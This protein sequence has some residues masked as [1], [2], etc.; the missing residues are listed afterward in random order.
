MRAPQ[1]KTPTGTSTANAHIRQAGWCHYAQLPT[2]AAAQPIGLVAR[3]ANDGCS[4]RSAALP[5]AAST[6]KGKQTLQ[7]LPNGRDTRATLVRCTANRT[8]SVPAHGARVALNARALPPPHAPSMPHRPARRVTAQGCR[9]R[10][11]SCDRAAGARRS[12]ADWR[13]DRNR[14]SL[15]PHSAAVAG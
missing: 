10:A 5:A 8:R 15:S 13:R 4:P 11:T 3:L 2:C 14:H 6:A 7:R 9:R 12:A 1:T